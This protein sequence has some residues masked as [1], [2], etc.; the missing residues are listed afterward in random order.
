MS[1]V[2]FF[3]RGSFDKI[4]G[5]IIHHFTLRRLVS[6]NQCN[7]VVDLNLVA[8]SDGVEQVGKGFVVRLQL[9]DLSLPSH[10]TPAIFCLITF[11]FGFFFSTLSTWRLIVALVLSVA[12]RAQGRS[13]LGN[14]NDFLMKELEIGHSY[15]AVEPGGHDFRT[16]QPPKLKK[17]KGPNLEKH[18]TGALLRTLE[19]RFLQALHAV[20]ILR[21]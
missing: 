20:V 12:V 14:N 7:E 16:K 13:G 1:I 17:R 9:L 5:N 4:G 2:G 10:L 21:R 11:T 15:R 6:P 3:G 18:Q 8:T 19:R